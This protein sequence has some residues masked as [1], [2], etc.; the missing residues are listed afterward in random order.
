[1][2]FREPKFD[3]P[4]IQSLLWVLLST[5]MWTEQILLFD[6]PNETPLWHHNLFQ[7]DR[8]LIHDQQI[9]FVVNRKT[10]K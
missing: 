5:C 8:L 6:Y 10:I 7:V 4:K 3:T 9:Q 2:N 1:M